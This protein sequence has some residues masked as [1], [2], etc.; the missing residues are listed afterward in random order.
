MTCVP[1]VPNPWR[2]GTFP[3]VLS[4]HGDE[5]GGVGRPVTAVALVPTLPGFLQQRRTVSPIG[6]PVT[7]PDLPHL[8]P[9]FAPD[10]C[11]DARA[12]RPERLPGPPLAASSLA[13]RAVAAGIAYRTFFGSLLPRA[14]VRTRRGIRNSGD[15]R[16][17]RACVSSNDAG[18]SQT[19]PRVS[20]QTTTRWILDWQP[21]GGSQIGCRQSSRTE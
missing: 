1:H 6:R 14:S 12:H 7:A 8:P 9:A 3:P 13:W 15:D 21:Q 20:A 19:P 17:C 11:A 10:V 4:A 5:P 18:T 2:C 16:S